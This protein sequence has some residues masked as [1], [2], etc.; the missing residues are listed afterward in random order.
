MNQSRS[1]EGDLDAPSPA[2]WPPA[3]EL[4][5]LVRTTW[6]SMNWQTEHLPQHGWWFRSNWNSLESNPR[7]WNVFAIHGLLWHLSCQDRDWPGAP[8][9][10]ALPT[11]RGDGWQD[12]LLSLKCSYSEQLSCLTPT[13]LWLL[14]IRHNF[15]SPFLLITFDLCKSIDSWGWGSGCGRENQGLYAYLEVGAFRHRGIR[16]H[17]SMH[18]LPLFLSSILF[19]F[20]WKVMAQNSYLDLIVLFILNFSSNGV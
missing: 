1:V 15:R 19:L 18:G 6:Q 10:Y 13:M 14:P 2:E 8:P 11:E 5:S 17:V 7:D 16:S 20:W 3:H 12:H 9:L 4:S